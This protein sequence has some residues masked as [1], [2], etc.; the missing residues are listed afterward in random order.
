ME[1]ARASYAPEI[2]VELLNDNQDQLEENLDRIVT[3]VENWY[4]DHNNQ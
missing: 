3:W 4:K 1:E 2:V